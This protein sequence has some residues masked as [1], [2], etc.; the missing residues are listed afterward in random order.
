MSKK[1]R[2]TSLSKHSISF[3][4]EFSKDDV[5]SVSVD[6]EDGRVYCTVTYVGGK[7]EV[8]EWS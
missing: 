1:A 2:K 5:A 4:K 3:E 7:K 6:K 8:V